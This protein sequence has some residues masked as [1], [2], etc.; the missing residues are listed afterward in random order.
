[1][2]IV[3]QDCFGTTYGED[4]ADFVCKNKSGYYISTSI[5]EDEEGISNYHGGLDAWLVFTD[6]NHNTIWERCYGGSGNESF[7]MM[8]PLEDGNAWIIGHSNST[9][10]DVTC[11]TENWDYWL[12]KIDSLGNILHQNCFGNCETIV[13]AISTPD[14][15]LLI[16][17][18]VPLGHVDGFIYKFDSLGNILWTKNIGTTFATEWF[19]S[20]YETSKGTWLITGMLYE[21]G[22]I[23]ECEVD[24]SVNYKDVWLVEID[25]TGEIIWQSCYGGS[26]H[27]QANDIIEVEDGYIIAA[28][29]SS[30]DIDVSG[31]H[32]NDDL[33]SDIW[34]FKINFNG[35]IIWQR[36][37][38]GS[39][40]EGVYNIYHTNDNNLEVLGYASSND[41][42]VIGHHGL[43]FSDVWYLRLDIEGNIL[44]SKCF[45]SNGHDMMGKE[46]MN[47][48]DDYNHI[49]CFTS[50]S[51]SGD[52]ECHLHPIPNQGEN[53]WVFQIKDCEFYTPT[54]PSQPIG[55]D[56]I[57]V[58]TDSIS[59]YSTNATNA[60]FYEWIMQPNNAGSI[61][62]ND[63]I[64]TISW[65]PDFEGTVNLKVRSSNDCGESDWSDELKIET[66]ICL[67]KDEIKKNIISVYP[68]PANNKLFVDRQQIHNYE[69]IQI[70]NCKG[71]IVYADMNFNK[72]SIDISSFDNGLYVLQYSNNESYHTI[73]FIVIK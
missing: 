2:D 25:D 58:N 3:W 45:G 53:N 37:Y 23:V 67:G 69:S 19:T 28:Q 59:N 8:I 22:E 18:H 51:Q 24:E 50:R 30:N 36:C 29:T 40:I 5:S 65:N 52:V 56:T 34:I 71:D 31:N 12:I 33:T 48:I 26:Y 16:V 68:N 43:S 6:L 39:D 63:S 1:M 55:I 73:K 62:R 70:V 9:D 13:D 15:G 11:A 4:N 35:E 61:L 60:S 27:E 49:L 46:M 57:C 20:I 44:H 32:S 54:V 7:K 72:R 10:G 66:Y 41:G 64:I 38:G 17:G 21:K 47:K 42:D 14:K